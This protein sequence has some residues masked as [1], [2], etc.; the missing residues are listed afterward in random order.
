MISKILLLI[1]YLGLV[2]TAIY[3]A[4][5]DSI[6]FGILTLS[7]MLLLTGGLLYNGDES[8]GGNG[9]DRHKD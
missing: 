6:T 1:G 4:F 8:E 3:M 7:L 9:Y 2:L 5:K